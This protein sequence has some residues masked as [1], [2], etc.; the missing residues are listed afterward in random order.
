MPELLLRAGR[1][2]IDP[3]TPGPLAGYA[4][5]GD[6]VSTG[7]HDP[8]EAALLVLDDATTRTAWLSL[9]ALAAPAPLAE[10]L[11][12]AV[13][14][15]LG[16]D[17]LPVVVAASHTHSAPLGWVGSIH[18]GYDGAVDP[19]K[20][21]ELAARVAELA[22]SL[23]ARPAE[24]VTAAWGQGTASRLGANRLDPAL[25]HDDSV[26]VLTLRS[27]ET[28]TVRAVLWDAATHPTV[29]GP[30]N[31]LL[32]A[33]WPGAARRAIRS[34]LAAGAAAHDPDAAPV[35]LFLQGAA[36]DVSTRFTRQGHGTAE[37]ARLGELAAAAA[38]GA[39]DQPSRLLAPSI[40]RA[41]RML[42]L[43]R[44]PLPSR[45][46]AEHELAG[47][48]AAL[49][50]LAHLPR[51]DPRVR[52]A[53]SRVEG[54]RVQCE[55][56]AAHPPPTVGLALSVTAID[57]VAWVHVPGELF[58]SIGERLRRRS[59]FPV[60]RVIGYADGYLGY[61]V[62]EAAFADKS[63]EALAGSLTPEAGDRI[64]DAAHDILKELR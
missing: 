12:D 37:V 58:S 38:I 31:L 60:T 48:V 5:R 4:A 46:D 18:P 62:D 30:G 43:E 59:P 21:D 55:L 41:S 13:R 29:F 8:L 25:P 50:E 39:I 33:D 44:R 57:D 10:R 35:V 34:A 7:V 64:V 26:G 49:A 24:A 22:A 61:L 2:G 40:R 15:G 3:R 42:E 51:T 36:G 6:A 14:A 32:S 47:T 9:D 56:V 1:T 19:D 27:A 16:D 45:A 52:L 54:A 28:G 11:R 17:A 53:Q 20:V 63:Y 23:A